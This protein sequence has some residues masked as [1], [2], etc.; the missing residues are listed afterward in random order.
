MDAT[1]DFS[2]FQFAEVEFGPFVTTT[3]VNLARFV[4]LAFT[5]LRAIDQ[6][7]GVFTVSKTSRL[8][9]LNTI[10]A[11]DEFFETVLSRRVG[12][13]FFDHIAGGVGQ[14]HPHVGNSLLTRIL[15][16]IV[17]TIMIHGAAEFRGN[18]FAE[19]VAHT[20]LTGL[21]RDTADQVI[22][23]GP[24]SRATDVA[25][26]G[27]PIEVAGRLNFTHRIDT[28][29]KIIEGIL[30]CRIRGCSRDLSTGLIQQD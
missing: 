27:S 14:H 30:P 17:V 12:Q 8:E 29:A 15:Q 13:G 25:D 4:V 19:I 28:R 5:T 9:F 10:F 26:Q 2:Q 6:A 7:E 24:A 18:V 23:G 22:S 16:A 21:Q 20:G 1:T 3:N 11:S